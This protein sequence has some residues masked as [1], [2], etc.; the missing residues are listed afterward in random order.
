MPSKTLIATAEVMTELSEASELGVEFHDRE[1][2]A[3]HS[4]RVDLARVNARVKQ[5]AADQ[6]AD[7]G[8]RLERDGVKILRGRGRLARADRGRAVGPARRRDAA[9]TARRRRSRPTRS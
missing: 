8:R 4:I 9:R 6:S 5:L 3:A 7:I 1:G 2:D